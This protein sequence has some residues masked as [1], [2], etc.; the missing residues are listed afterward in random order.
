MKDNKFEV[1]LNESIEE[2][3]AANYETSPCVF[4]IDVS[5]EKDFTPESFKK[6]KDHIGSES[7]DILETFALNTIKLKDRFLEDGGHSCLMH[8]F[9][10]IELLKSVKSSVKKHK[11]T[12]EF[13]TQLN[14]A[15]QMALL[16]ME[17]S[18]DLDGII[19]FIKE[20]MQSKDY[21][22]LAEKI[23]KATEVNCDS[24]LIEIKGHDKNHYYSA[25]KSK[26]SLIKT[27][28]DKD[29]QQYL[30]NQKN[31]GRIVKLDNILQINQSNLVILL[32]GVPFQDSAKM[33]RLSDNLVILSDVANRF[34][35]TLA[36]EENL[37]K[38]EKERQSFLNTLSHELR[39]PLN[40]I[41]GFSKALKSKSPEK[42]L[43]ESGIDVLTRIITNS[44][45]INAII[46]TL[47][48]ISGNHCISSEE[49]D[50]KVDVDALIIR[51]QNEFK[52]AASAKGLTFETNY[53]PGLHLFNDPARIYNILKR[54][55]DN[56][57]KFTHSGFVRINVTTDTDAMQTQQIIFQV[58]DTGI[59]IDKKHHHK[60]FHEI[61]QLN[62]EHDRQHYGVGLG[63]YYSHLV[64]QQ[65]N[66]ELTVQSALGEG[67]CF[68]LSLPITTNT[69]VTE[70]AEE[71][72]TSHDDID[73]F[74]F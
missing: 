40:S 27:N 3:L 60:L 8:P 55:V 46:S 24:C 14:E 49:K 31:A 12:A 16:A 25:C 71:V 36:I 29:M 19:S 65:L 43:G 7:F 39:T 70:P 30:L 48:E 58:K 23:F 73:D 61:G 47:I 66:G 72:T 34:A 35:Q 51:L 2:W 10:P 57:I 68:S 15:S 45:Q 64:A 32:D 6:L 33:E 63:L 41:L 20:A 5:N 74:L 13:H 53:P 54:L 1:Q 56:A 4:I 18:S 37:D 52:D 28:I 26:G 50:Q 11:S 59:G 38:T 44:E 17:N 62:T 67:S 22:E 69:K 9:G 21:T 42:P